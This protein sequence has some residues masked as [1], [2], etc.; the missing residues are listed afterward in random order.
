MGGSALGCVKKIW[1]G[2]CVAFTVIQKAKEASEIN[3]KPLLFDQPCGIVFSPNDFPALSVTF[4]SNVVPAG[5]L[6]GAVYWNL[7]SVSLTSRL[8]TATVSIVT[9]RLS[10]FRFC[11]GICTSVG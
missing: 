11:P 6:P 2:R 3:L 4:R 10:L 8:V 7:I 1:I 5:L 9:T